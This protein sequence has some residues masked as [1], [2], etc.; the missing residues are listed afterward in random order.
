MALGDE[1]KEGGKEGG[2]SPRGER[3]GGVGQGDGQRRKGEE[4]EVKRKERAG[5]W[6]L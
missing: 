4:R 5:T 1:G 2:R 6:R 3:R